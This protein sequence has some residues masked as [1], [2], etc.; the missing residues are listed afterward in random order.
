MSTEEQP[1]PELGI[2]SLTTA[3]AR[4]CAF[5]AYTN[6]THFYKSTENVNV[7]TVFGLF[8]LKGTWKYSVF[9]V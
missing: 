5:T 4:P 8:V 2:K 7:F 6:N 9:E 3:A 1:L